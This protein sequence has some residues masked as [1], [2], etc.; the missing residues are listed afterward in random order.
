MCTDKICFYLYPGNTFYLDSS[1]SVGYAHRCVFQAEPQSPCLTSGYR[2][3]QFFSIFNSQFIT[4]IVFQ[5]QQVPP[6]S[7]LFPCT[8]G[9]LNPVGSATSEA[10]SFLPVCWLLFFA[11]L[12]LKGS[13]RFFPYIIASLW[14]ISLV[15]F[16]IFYTNV[17]V[18]EHGRNS[19]AL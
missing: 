15:A 4:K 14:Q 18:L 19:F 3:S 2:C 6:Q 7:T 9:Y 11:A 13:S 8:H 12:K 10:I 16:I 5:L 17:Q 1:I